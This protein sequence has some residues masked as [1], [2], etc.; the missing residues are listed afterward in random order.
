MGLLDFITA[1]WEWIKSAIHKAWSRFKLF[2]TKVA[3]FAKTVMTGIKS[4]V[5]KAIAWSSNFLQKLKDKTKKLF[6][7]AIRR[8]PADPFKD[9]IKKA[10]EGG[11]VG[12]IDVPAGDLGLTSSADVDIH[13]VQSDENGNTENVHS[14]RADQITDELRSRLGNGVSEINLKF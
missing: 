7:V 5:Q 9:V 13:I 12:T 11:Q 14:I 6:L 8:T 1:S 10:Q 3:N 4:L 2:F